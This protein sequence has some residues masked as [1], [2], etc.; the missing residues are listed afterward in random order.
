MKIKITKTKNNKKSKCSFVVLLQENKNFK[1][2]LRGKIELVEI[3]N[4]ALFCSSSVVPTISIRKT[5]SSTVVYQICLKYERNQVKTCLKQLY[6][7]LKQRNI[8]LITY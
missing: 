3:I 6:K 8:N 7:F 2:F 4:I 5:C 1:H